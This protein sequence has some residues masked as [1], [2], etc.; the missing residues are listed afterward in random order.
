MAACSSGKKASPNEIGADWQVDPLGGLNS[1]GRTPQLVTCRTD[2]R[3]R[4]VSFC[5]HTAIITA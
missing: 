3:I 4:R 1:L 5:T 2:Q